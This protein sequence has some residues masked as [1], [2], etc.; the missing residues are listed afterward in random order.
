MGGV[1]GAE[2]WEGVITDGGEVGWEESGDGGELAFGGGGRAVGCGPVGGGGRGGRRGRGGNGLK[3][4]V[5]RGKRS[6]PVFGVKG[7]AYVGV[8][9]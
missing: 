1:N 3:R 5:R 9:D 6:P 8:E 2:G 4:D 7:F